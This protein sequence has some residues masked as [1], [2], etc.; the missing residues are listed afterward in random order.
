[1]Q[2]I[3]LIQVYTGDGKGKTTAAVGLASRAVAHGLKVCYIYF[4]KDPDK[5]EYGELKTLKKCGVEIYGFAKKHPH[6]Y[7]DVSLE[8]IRQECLSAIKFIKQIYQEKYDILILDEILISVRDKFI[9]EEELLDLVNMKPEKLEL[10]LTGR[11]A[12]E[13]IIKQADLVS[14]IKKVKH[15]YDK[16]IQKRKG[17]EY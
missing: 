2:K 3:G 15:P 16:G 11:G 17:I 4:H 6:F 7:K 10:V 8:E 9:T 12:T 14:E 5:W 1:M 13:K